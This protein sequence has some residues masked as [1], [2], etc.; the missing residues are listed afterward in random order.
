MA[1]HT[2]TIRRWVWN[3]THPDD[4]KPQFSRS[5]MG[6]VFNLGPDL[7]S[8]G[9]HFTLARY[10]GWGFLLNGDVVSSRTS[11]QQAKLRNVME[12]RIN[13]KD[14]TEPKQVHVV[15]PFSAMRAAG[16]DLDT[17]V[18][19]DTR[20]A[21]SG[22]RRARGNVLPRWMERERVH[23][24]GWQSI[25][26]YDLPIY[27]PPISE[28][29]YSWNLGYAPMTREKRHAKWREYVKENRI[30]TLDDGRLEWDQPFHQLGE[31]IFKAKVSVRGGEPRDAMFISA[32]D[33]QDTQTYFLSE[34]PHPVASLTEAYEALKPGTVKLAE[35]EGREVIRQGDIFAVATEFTTHQ[36][37]AMF[38]VEYGCGHVGMRPQDCGCW[39][40]P[41]MPK[42]NGIR[43]I[44]DRILRMQSLLDT[45]HVATEQ[46]RLP[47]GAVLARGILHHKPAFRDPD[48]RR[49][50]MGRKRWFLIVKNTVPVIEQRDEERR[51]AA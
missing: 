51:G 37:K 5:A 9:T 17:V 10:M 2:D 29:R 16:I 21:T 27:G 34:L 11:G 18:P 20:G 39:T 32:W 8:F 12:G 35:I 41:N 40:L 47:N 33:N 19:V 45:N 44:T 1:S 7:Y 13:W 25:D 14:D 30:V 3:M 48:H 23:L 43:P 6:T 28:R 49:Q 24:N 36:V 4:P 15:I 50:V 46:V 42:H 26:D 22:V 38:P 31:C